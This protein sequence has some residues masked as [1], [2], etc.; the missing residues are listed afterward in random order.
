MHE[1]CALRGRLV[2][3]RHAVTGD[4]LDLDGLGAV[5]RR[6]ARSG[7]HH[8]HGFAR[9]A[10]DV[11]GEQRHLRD[12]EVLALED[13]TQPGRSR[14]AASHTSTTPG[15]L[16][17]APASTDPIRAAA[18]GARANA[19]CSSPAGATSSTN[20]DA[21]VSRRGS[22]TRRTGVPDHRAPLR[23]DARAAAS[24]IR[25]RRVA[26]RPPDQRGRE[27]LRY[28]ELPWMSDG[29][30]RSAAAALPA[31]S[32]TA[33]SGVVPASIASASDART[34]ASLTPASA[35]RAERTRPSSISRAV[36]TATIA[37]SP[38]AARTRGSPNVAPV[39]G[40]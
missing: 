1:R 5:L 23:P 4:V 16:R 28:S 25:T 12:H 36:A 27:L 38:A 11:A 19:A 21:P 2:D 39:R 30:R 40:T 35:I 22:S 32:N 15:T 10:H 7:E 26:E 8:R 3:R 29:G 37:K 34:G 31:S 24:A 14:S 18:N 6:V 33:S 13:G 9:E 17:A 20:R